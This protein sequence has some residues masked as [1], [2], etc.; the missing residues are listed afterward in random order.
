MKMNIGH[1]LKLCRSAKNLSLEELAGYAGLSQS[2]LSMIETNKRDPTLAT[3]EKLATA[4]DI[5]MPILLFLAADKDE[6]SGLDAETAQ[7]LS[8]AAIEVMRA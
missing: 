1:A 2:Y 6:L 5:P 4:L 3:I 8:T 7:R